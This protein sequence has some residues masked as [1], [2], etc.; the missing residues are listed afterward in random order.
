MFATGFNAVQMLSRMADLAPLASVING[1]V[2]FDFGDGNT[3]TL[4]NIALVGSI[5]DDITLI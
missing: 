1:N 3:L 5:M 2:V 4:A